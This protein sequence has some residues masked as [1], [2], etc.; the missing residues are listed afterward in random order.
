MVP[1]VSP[2]TSV[3]TGPRASDHARALSRPP[4]E[5]RPSASWGPIPRSPRIRDVN[6]VARQ[7]PPAEIEREPR[8]RVG[9]RSFGSRRRRRPSSPTASRLAAAD[10]PPARSGRWRSRRSHPARAG[11]RRADWC[12]IPGS[13]HPDRRPRPP[14][15]RRGAARPGELQSAVPSPV[16]SCGPGDGRAPPRRAVGQAPAAG[17]VP[18][19]D[20]LADARGHPGPLRAHGQSSRSPPAQGAGAMPCDSA[21]SRDIQSGRQSLGR[22]PARRTTAT[23]RTSGDKRR[24]APGS[25]RIC[26]SSSTP[27]SSARCPVYARCTITSRSRPRPSPVPS[28]W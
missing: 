6:G 4:A 20:A 3:P 8:D 28:R 27:A 2:L 15:G 21:P 5:N 10:G 23:P 26:I 25:N 1:P 18:G 19:A 11:A 7:P 16:R 17:G 12:P 24:A 14:A 22:S 13:S 9:N